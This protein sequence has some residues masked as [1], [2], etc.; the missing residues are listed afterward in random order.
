MSEQMNN[1]NDKRVIKSKILKSEPVKWRELAFI[2]Q[3]DFKALTPE[4]EQKLRTS[5]IQNDFTDPFKVWQDGDMI[6]CLDGRHRH[7]VLD[8]MIAEGIAVPVELPANFIDCKD[9]QEAAK[10]VLRAVI[11]EKEDHIEIINMMFP[12]A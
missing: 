9:K 4:D 11:Q 12:N 3:D 5:I 10:L 1:T 6:Y 2:Q 8:K 7:L